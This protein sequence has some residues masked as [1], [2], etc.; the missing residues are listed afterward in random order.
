MLEEKIKEAER[1]EEKTKQEK[2]EETTEEEIILKK[3]FEVEL[4]QHS[5][6]ATKNEE[7]KRLPKLKLHPEIEE[8]GNT[9]LSEHLKT[10]EKTSRRLQLHATPWEKQQLNNSM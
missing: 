9:I 4:M 8:S 7:R 2:L 1:V 3:A 5:A 6:D 10:R